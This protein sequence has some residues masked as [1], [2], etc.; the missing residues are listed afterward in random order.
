MDHP[1]KIEIDLIEG[2]IHS[3]HPAHHTQPAPSK[4]PHWRAAQAIAA[5]QVIVSP[6][7]LGPAN[8]GTMTSGDMMGIDGIDVSGEY[9]VYG[10]R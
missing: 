4:S 3:A 6:R 10:K 5:A 9:E 1:I 2:E 8:G 7:E